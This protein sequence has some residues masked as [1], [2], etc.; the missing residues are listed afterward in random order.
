MSNKYKILEILK[1]NDY[2]VKEIAENSDF[3]ENEVR[4]YIHRLLKDGL[5]KRIGKKE[6]YT[7]Y[8]AIKKESDTNSEYKRYL[9][10]LYHIMSDYMNP[11]EDK[12]NEFLEK[13][14][15]IEEIKELIE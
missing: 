7:I 9:K 11:K 14:P 10:Q 2:T 8:K 1:V 6:R 5:I 15:I 3:N 4:T 12:I 13:M